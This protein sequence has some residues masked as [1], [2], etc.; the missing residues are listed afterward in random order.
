MPRTWAGNLAKVNE[1]VTHY[2]H[3][4]AFP[5]DHCQGPVV[6]GWIGK[7]ADDITKETQIN[8]VGAIC[9]LCGARPQAVI[10]PSLALAFRP[11]EWDWEVPKQTHTAQMDGDPSSTELSS[12]VDADG[13]LPQSHTG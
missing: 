12:D 11:V 8:G 10:D 2:L 13:N 6:V 7:R 4:L 3:L 9:L 1:R 5:C